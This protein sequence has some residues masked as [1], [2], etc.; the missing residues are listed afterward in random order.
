MLRNTRKIHRWLGASLFVLFLIVS[1]SGVF[2]GWKKNSSGYI[3]P[4]TQ[5]GTTTDVAQWLS[6]DS[7]QSI[8]HKTLKDSINSELSIELSRI[9]ARPEKGILKFVFENHYWSIQLDGATGEVLNIGQRRSDWIENVHDGSIVDGFL[10]TNGIFILLY[11]SL[12]GLALLGF[13]VTGFWLWYGPK[14]MR[15]TNR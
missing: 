3:L 15:K 7:L 2:L 1:L 13:T 10:G 9:D 14:H 4:K 5:T 12:M 11:T 6:L 8:A